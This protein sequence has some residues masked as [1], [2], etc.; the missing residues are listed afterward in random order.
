M[1]KV[2]AGKLQPYERQKLNRMKRELSS[3]VNSRHAGI[4]VMSVE[5]IPNRMIAE[6]AH[7][8]PQWVRQIIHRF[9]E[10]GIE[11]DRGDQMVPLHP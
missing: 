1:D 7:C 8:S 2:R 11:G 9:N 3:Q 4:I 10:Q 5:G 6:H